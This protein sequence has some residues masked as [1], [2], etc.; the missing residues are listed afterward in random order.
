MLK[1]RQI[2]KKFMKKNVAI[3]L[4]IALVSSCQNLTVDEKTQKNLKPIWGEYFEQALDETKTINVIVAT[5][6]KAKSPIFACSDDQ[7]GVMIGSTL[8][9]GTC[10]IIRI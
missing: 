3:A 4:V 7:F 10:K 5:N 2:P 1:N 8:S 9:L 6:R